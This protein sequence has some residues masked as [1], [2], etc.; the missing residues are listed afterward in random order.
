M[1][2]CNICR[3]IQ[4]LSILHSI[5]AP[6]L[7]FAIDIPGDSYPTQKHIPWLGSGTEEGKA[8]PRDCKFHRQDN[9]ERCQEKRKN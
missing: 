5:F 9:R 6:C 1:N 4:L 7:F 3:E 2:V 8:E